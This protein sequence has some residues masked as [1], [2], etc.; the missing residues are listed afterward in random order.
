M[1]RRNFL[2]ALAPLAFSRA[3]AWQASKRPARLRITDVRVVPLRK[4]KDVGSLEPAWNPGR[5]LG[6][7]VGGG[8]FLEVRTDQGLVGRLHDRLAAALIPHQ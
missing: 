1:D 7:R 2:C 5:R 8:A 4:I 3:F 6:F